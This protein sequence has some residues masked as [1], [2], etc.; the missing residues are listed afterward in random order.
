[1]N[2]TIYMPVGE[3][4]SS[5]SDTYREKKNMVTLINTSD[6]LEG[7]VLNH[8]RVPNSNLK[9]QFKKTFQRDDILY[10]E[11]RP[12]NRRFAY[13]DFSPI[14]YIASTKLMVI[15]AKKDVVSP[16]YLYYFL[17]NSSTV[18]ELQLL[19]ETRSGTFP[20]IT[21]SEVANL[22]IPVP[23]LAVQE[24][25]VQT[26]Q[27]LEDKITCN[28]QINDNLQQQ[29][30]SVFDNLIANAENNDYTVSDYA[31]LNPKRTLAKNQVARSIDMSQLSTSGAFPSGWEMKPFNGGMRF[32]NG[33]TLLAR[34]T[35]CLENGKT[36]F[37]DFLDDGEV[38]FGSTEYIVLAPKN[39]TPPEMLYCLAR[40][41]AFVDYA[42]KNMNGSSGRQRVSAETVGQYRLSL[43]DKHS[44]VL[45]K[46]VVSPM[47]LKMRYNSLENMRL[48]ELRDALLPK[49]M[50]GEIDVS[51]VQL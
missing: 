30:F 35:P 47:F 39:D 37:I 29:A 28:E 14:D 7:R 43:F 16:K 15:R 34:I 46:E 25:I 44:L 51:A 42:V 31:F 36:A 38:A 24:V 32:T 9:G 3:V 2:G 17:K 13:V 1:M 11:I 8:E 26:M 6:V 5:I 19:A 45:F 27:C 10:S 23:S 33:D 20:Q 40:Y 18:A 49:L 21:F 12:Q 50:S 4:C 48:A 41:P 22:T